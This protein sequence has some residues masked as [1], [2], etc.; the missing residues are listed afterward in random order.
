MT[1]TL[2]RPL[3]YCII[4]FFVF[5]CDVFEL[6]IDERD[7][8]IA[9]EWKIESFIGNGEVLTEEEIK[10][11]NPAHS[12]NNYRLILNEDYT[13]SRIEVN[14]EESNGTWSLISGSTQLKLELS[15]SQSETYLIIDL[16]VRRLEIKFSGSNEVKPGENVYDGMLDITYV[17]EPVKG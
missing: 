11:N 15:E 8:F 16:Q 2:T 1:T 7:F 9:K 10:A 17:L 5:A 12:L 3:I 6:A 13:F 4:T 14:G